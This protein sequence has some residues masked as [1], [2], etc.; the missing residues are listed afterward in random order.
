MT[1]PRRV[2]PLPTAGDA[3]AATRGSRL[4]RTITIGAALLVI[5]VVSSGWLLYCRYTHPER[6]R[7][8]AKAYLQQRVRGTVSIESASYSWLRGVRLYDVTVR[9]I[10]AQSPRPGSTVPAAFDGPVFTCREVRLSTARGVGRS[11]VSGKLR[12]ESVVALEPVCRIV[13]NKA[14]GRTN[15]DGLL[16]LSDTLDDPEPV[17]LPTIELRNLRVSVAFREEGRERVVEDLSLTIRARPSDEHPDVYDVV[18]RGDRDV[19]ASGHSR[20][21]LRTGLVRNVRGGLPG[22]S[23]EAVMLAIN[24]RYDGAAAWCELLGLDGKVRVTDYS[25]TGLAGDGL[26]SRRDASDASPALAE[27]LATIELR[28]ASISIPINELERPLPPQQRYLRVER[29]SG[30]VDVTPAAIEAEFA[31]LFHGSDCRVS[32]RIRSEERKLLSLDDASFDAHVSVEGLELPRIDPT[33]PPSEVRFI[34]HWPRLARFYCDYDPH[35]RVD[36]DM[37]VAKPA[38]SAEPLVVPRVV[39]D[40][41]GG[42]ASCRYFPY[43][44]RD[45]EGRVECSTEGVTIRNLHGEHDGGIVSVSGH[46]DKPTKW[47]A[48]DVTVSGKGIVFDEALYAALPDRYRRIVEHFVP[49]G[50]IDVHIDLAQAAGSALAPA[51]WRSR[52][53][54]FLRD[55][56]ATYSGF[57]YPVDHL[58]GTILADGDRLEVDVAGRSGEAHVEVDGGITFEGKKVADLGLS[59]RAQDVAIDSTLRQALPRKIQRAIDVLHPRGRFDTTTTLALDPGTGLVAHESDLTLRDVAIRYEELPVEVTEISGRLHVARDTI[60]AIDLTGRHGEAVVSGE[61]LLRTGEPRATGELLLRCRDLRLE[62]SLRSA[63]PMTVRSVL[64]GWE[65]DGP[66]NTETVVRWLPAGSLETTTART[67]VGLAGVAVSHDAVSAALQDVRGEI[68]IDGS[69]VQGTNIRARYGPAA[70]RVDFDSRGAGADGGI[71]KGTVKLSATDLALG[72]SLRGL[73]P[74]SWKT[75]WERLNPSGSVDLHIDPLR[76]ERTGA[77]RSREWHVDGYMELNEVTLRQVVDIERMSGTL[78]GSGAVVDR[79][80]G[81]ALRGNLNLPSVDVLGQRLEHVESGWYFARTAGGEG[82]LAIESLQGRIH[83]GSVTGKIGLAF[84][85]GQAD[86]DVSATVHGMQIGPLSNAGRTSESEGRGPVQARGRADGHLYLSGVVG[87]PTQKRGGG[88]F[89]IVDGHI[90]RLPLILAILHVL[91][92]SIPDADV[93]DDAR[94]DFFISGNRVQLEDIVLRDSALALVGTGSLT[95]PDRGLDLDLVNVGVHRWARVPLLTDFVEGASREFVE[96]HVTGP[97]SRPTV[98]ARPLRAFGEEF[99]RLFRKR[100]PTRTQAAPS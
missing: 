35:G 19:A 29:V 21:D 85:A 83:E 70:I 15:L 2:A 46:L 34:N 51:R 24:A 16:Q 37:D 71:E 78:V 62:E 61:G 72:D 87:D 54:I 65:I 94:A 13:R 45:L 22:M 60:R 8:L 56:S 31:G 59:I 90:Y 12:V 3:G 41:A 23:I 32:V 40:A 7:A 79:L 88:R 96:L 86:Y 30:R 20:V 25:F 98:R 97:L 95:L 64:G 1:E 55:V 82:V 47:A 11:L 28:E 33:A 66:I 26:R 53:A 42:D 44:V 4:R 63:L 99:K 14:D 76:Y 89:E 75:V 77:N 73:L 58:T 10:G 69:H 6:I 50:T 68:T 52:S 57:P 43:R 67:V 49:E 38:G 91:N 74:K 100:K 18:W 39:L 84:D 36:L 17:P 5:T 9:P 92:L 48:K 27:G 93:F 81:T 80:G